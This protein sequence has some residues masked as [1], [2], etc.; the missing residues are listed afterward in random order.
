MLLHV[1]VEL[2][3]GDEVV[4][5]KLALSL[6]VQGWGEAVLNFQD[7][8][9]KLKSFLRKLFSVIR[10][11]LSWV[12]VGHDPMGDNCFGYACDYSRMMRDG[13]K[14]FKES[15]WDDQQASF[16]ARGSDK[17]ATNIDRHKL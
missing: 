10:Q 16:A 11:V 12:A 8:S 3:G 9:Y 13:T 14:L 1:V 4:A 6:G 7:F 15:I 5:F 17:L 2:G